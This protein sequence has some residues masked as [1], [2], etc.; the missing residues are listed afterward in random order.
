MLVSF[1]Q[2]HDA[3][4][5]VISLYSWSDVQTYNGLTADYNT[6]NQDTNILLGDY[7]HELLNSFQFMY[8]DAYKFTGGPDIITDLQK[9]MQISQILSL[10]ES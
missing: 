7:N 8:D 10:I 2:R 6:I 4:R 9:L 3:Q 1:C 5:S